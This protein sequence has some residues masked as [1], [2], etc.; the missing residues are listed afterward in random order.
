MTAM[1]FILWAL[2]IIAALFIG[3]AKS[4]MGEKG[5]N[6]A[7]KEDL[8][9]VVDQVKVVTRTTEQ[10]RTELS[11]ATWSKQRH[12]DLKRD[13]A[14][15]IMRA[16]GTLLEI[17]YDLFTSTI[18]RPKAIVGEA[19]LPVDPKHQAAWDAASARFQKQLTHLWE[20]EQIT[21]LIFPENISK[22]FATLKG[23]FLELRS[24]TYEDSTKFFPL[25]RKLEEDQKILGELIK[26][27]LNV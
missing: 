2:S 16:Y 26:A 1:Y 19:Y 27:D 22:Q 18:G 10:I 5:K 23:T 21:S 20:L 12:W 11:E 17:S 7:T 4:Y 13:T 25:I 15:E 6:L 24:G 14:L 3:A 8:Q 9:D